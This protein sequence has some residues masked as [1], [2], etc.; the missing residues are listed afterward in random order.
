LSASIIAK[1]LA[2]IINKSFELGYFPSTFKIAKVIPIHKKGNSDITENYRPISLLNNM[3]KLF[4]RI[5]FN[6]VIKF[7][8][9]FN[10]LYENQFGFRPGHSTTDVLFSS[11]NMLTMENANKN[12]MLGIFLDLSKAFD[13]VDHNILLYKLFNCGIR[14]NVYNWFKSYL[15]KRQQYTLIGDSASQVMPLS[16]GVPQGSI[17]GPLLFLIYVNDIQYACT[18]AYP[19]LFADDSNL[20]VKGRDLNELYQAANLACVEISHWFP[21]Y[22]FSC[23]MHF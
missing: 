21:F 14:G 17:L 20:F 2:F 22:I 23:C 13:T 15:S 5:M 19:K 12:K 10:I 7:F 1:P 4:E 16:V 11:L 18:N 8:N 3:S 9:Q 6:R